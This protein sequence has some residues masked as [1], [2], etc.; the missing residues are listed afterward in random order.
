MLATLKEDAPL[1]HLY[2]GDVLE[3]HMVKSHEGNLIMVQ[4]DRGGLVPYRL[5]KYRK[6]SVIVSDAEGN[7]VILTKA[8]AKE[9]YAGKVYALYRGEEVIDRLDREELPKVEE[10]I[11]ND[12]NRPVWAN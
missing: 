11:A 3:A 9:R 1:F 2:R 12:T 4:D 5:E 7:E 10:Q 6:H 8:Q